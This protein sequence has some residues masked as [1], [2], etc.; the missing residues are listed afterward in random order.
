MILLHYL[1]YVHLISLFLHCL[2]KLH[3]SQIH[4]I[5]HVYY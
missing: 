2:L 4:E 1:G 5:F 3:Y